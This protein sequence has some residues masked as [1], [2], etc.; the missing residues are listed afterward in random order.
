MERG[1][2]RH[3]KLDRKADALPPPG[4][5][6]E[7]R[8]H[9]RSVSLFSETH[10]LIAVVGLVEGTA[11]TVSPVDYKKGSPSAARR[12]SQVSQ[13]FSGGH[14]PPGRNEGGDVSAGPCRRVLQLSV[15]ASDENEVR[16][17]LDG[18]GRLA[19]EI[20]RL[21]PARDDLRPLYVTGHG[22]TVGKTGGV[23]Q[24]RDKKQ[25][26][27]EARVNEISQV[28]LFGSVTMTAAAVQGLC[29]A[30]KPIAHFSYGGWF[31]GLTEGLGL[32][33]VFL[34]RAQFQRADDGTFCLVVARD[35]VST[36]IRNQR[37]LLQ[38]NHVEPSAVALQQLRRLA[39]HASAA[40]DV[41]VLLGIEGSAARVYFEHLNG[42]LKA[43][44]ESETPSFDFRTRNRR[45]PKD[46]INAL[47][48][49]G[50]SLLA[51]VVTGELARC[52][53]FETR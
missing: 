26:I 36:K 30:E 20:R 29:W 28:N 5:E 13:V 48:S 39:Q 4:E 1:A 23:L 43:E 33:N 42:M 10:K 37:T 3:E 44:D 25:L 24:I 2:P 52:P 49:F 19:G 16:R 17:P 15:F 40:Q 46:P 31:Y 51:R 35:I 12:Q 32:K 27:Q 9:F 7:D 47:L 38:R 53:G 22:F 18:T 50:Y 11:S 41:E 8:I 21:V 14:L 45:P 34:R 6:D